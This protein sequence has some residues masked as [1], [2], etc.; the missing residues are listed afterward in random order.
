M[1]KSKYCYVIANEE[2]GNMLVEDGKLPIYWS[3]KVAKERQLL[4]GDKYVVH[5][6]ELATIENIVLSSKRA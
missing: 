5:K 4:F 3:K 1:A 2:N 6:I